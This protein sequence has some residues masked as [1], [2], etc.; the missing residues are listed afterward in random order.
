MPFG[1][2]RAKACLDP[3]QK[4]GRQRNFGQ[5]HQSLST[6]AEAFGDGLKIDFG[7]T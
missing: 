7:L 5:E 3:V 1:G 6:L 2:K 4:F